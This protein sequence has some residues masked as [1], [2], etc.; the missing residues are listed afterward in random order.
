MFVCFLCDEIRPFCVIKQRLQE[1][2]RLFLVGRYY[3]LFSEAYH[4]SFKMKWANFERQIQ[5]SLLPNCV[6]WQEIFDRMFV[7]PTN[8]WDMPHTDITQIS[9]K[10]IPDIRKNSPSVFVQ[11]FT[12]VH[13]RMLFRLME[14]CFDLGIAVEFQKCYLFVEW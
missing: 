11:V 10:S 5:Y 13:G 9:S 14:I 6:C 7:M 4:V 2:D 1:F 12:L 3:F 8:N